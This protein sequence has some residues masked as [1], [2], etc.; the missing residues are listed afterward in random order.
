MFEPVAT[1]YDKYKSLIDQY[2]ALVVGKKLPFIGCTFS[3]EKP[4]FNFY[5]L[6]DWMF[7]M[8]KNSVLHS[9]LYINYF[10]NQCRMNPSKF[11]QPDEELDKLIYKY[12]SDYI[13]YSYT[14]TDGTVTALNDYYYIF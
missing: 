4:I 12:E 3:V 10:N 7:D 14:Q 8:T 11:S 2:I 5:A 9:Q 13:F 1:F 6:D